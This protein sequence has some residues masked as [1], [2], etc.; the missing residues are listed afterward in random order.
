MRDEGEDEDE[1]EGK[2]YP[3]A[4]MRT[5]SRRS[6]SAR[7]VR[8]ASFGVRAWPLCS[9]TT[10]SIF[11]PRMP[12][13][14]GSETSVWGVKDLPLAVTLIVCC[15]LMGCGQVLAYSGVARDWSKSFQTGS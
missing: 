8:R 13:K 4:T 10:R 5:I 9:T 14:S 2:F 7:S 6:P 3:P 15:S 12:T 1:G 11:R